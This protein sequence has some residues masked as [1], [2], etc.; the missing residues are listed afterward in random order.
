MVSS[1]NGSDWLE[2]IEKLVATTAGTA[3]PAPLPRG[4]FHCRLDDQPDHLV[5]ERYLRP[6]VVENPSDRPL[7]LNPD[8]IFVR[9]GEALDEKYLADIPHPHFAYGQNAGSYTTAWV[10]DSATG[11]LAPFWI[12]PEL[13]ELLNLEPGQEAPREFHSDI[14]RVL[15]SVGIFVEQGHANNRREEWRR[16]VGVCAPHFHEKGY[17]PIG[18][19]IHPYHIG[20]LRRYYRHQL[21]TGAYPLGDSQT[22]LRFAA[23]NE[24]VARFFHQQL[25]AAVSDIAG[26]RVK[27]SYVYL[28]S[29]QEGAI[30]KEH[31]DREQCEFSITLCLDY[32]PEPSLATPWPLRLHTKNGSV[33]VYQALGDA[34]LYRGREIPHSRRQLP[35]GHSSTSLFFHYVKEDFAG[36][37]D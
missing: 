19:L 31:V 6:E 36:P 5:P 4:L 12:E 30:L 24:P 14:I 7:V 18:R 13:S 27:P 34:L 10:R 16:I 9:P 15:R 20:A 3:R 32:S 22:E 37:L 25:T 2:W 11:A 29:Y 23:S 28:S 33:A 17:V 21:R 8:C 1:L 35:T 26:Q